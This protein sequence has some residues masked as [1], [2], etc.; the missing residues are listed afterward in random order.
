LWKRQN[1]P[2]QAVGFESWDRLWRLSQE[3]GTVTLPGKIE[4]TRRGKLIVVRR[5]S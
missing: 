5:R 2:R 4:A 1:W 3:G